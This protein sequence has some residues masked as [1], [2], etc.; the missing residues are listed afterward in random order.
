MQTVQVFPNAAASPLSVTLCLFQLS[1]ASEAASWS[2]QGNSSSGQ[3]HIS[4]DPVPLVRQQLTQQCGRW[5]LTC[6]VASARD[7][8]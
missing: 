5:C 4:V 6:I 8:T 7:S 1:S 2:P 3:T